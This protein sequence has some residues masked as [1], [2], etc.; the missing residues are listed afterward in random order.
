MMKVS[1]TQIT[2]TKQ[3]E[4]FSAK[5]YPDPAS[6]DGRPITIGWGH[7]GPEVRL[8][9]VISEATGE[10]YLRG[11]MER[12][13]NEVR[14]LVK[15]PMTQGQFD[16]LCDMVFN[17]GSAF[18]REDNIKGDFDDMI[19]AGDKFEI[20]RRI[21]DFRL[22][23]GKVQPGLVRRRAINQARWDGLDLNECIK[24]GDRALAAYR[25]GK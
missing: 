21:T 25:A 7:T 24:A 16:C 4:G 11:D 5:A 19:R 13:A 17:M 14:R 2:L 9:M 12:A 10:K 22:A 1:D 18:M 6:K 20:R 23:S 15:F 8:G 3:C